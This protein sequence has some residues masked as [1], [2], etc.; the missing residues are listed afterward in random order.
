MVNKDVDAVRRGTRTAART[1]SLAGKGT[2]TRRHQEAKSMNLLKE[3]GLRLIEAKLDLAEK[4]GDR[5]ADRLRFA[6]PEQEHW[7]SLDELRRGY[8][9]K[10]EG[11]AELLQKLEIITEAE[12]HQIFHQ[13]AR[14]EGSEPA[15]SR[16]TN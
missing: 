6:H 5:M 10:I 4:L 9:T 15:S 2:G 11:M 12:M 8:L 14:L 1:N 13:C 3:R 7:R 16:R